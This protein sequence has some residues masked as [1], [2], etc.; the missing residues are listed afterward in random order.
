MVAGLLYLVGLIT[1]LVCI[2]IAGYGAPSMIASFTA[3]MD[4]GN[5]NMLEVVTD[6][7]GSLAWMIWPGITGLTLMGFGRVIM[8]LGAINRNL[9][10]GS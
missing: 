6:L 7:A 4:A 10:G 3:A 9:R 8:L 1:V 5:A 2:A